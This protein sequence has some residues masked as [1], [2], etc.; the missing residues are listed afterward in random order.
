MYNPKDNSRKWR[1]NFVQSC[2]LEQSS[3]C[4]GANEINNPSVKTKRRP[5][6]RKLDNLLMIDIPPTF[7]EVE[8]S[9]EASE[10][11]KLRSM[12]CPEEDPVLTEMWRSGVCDADVGSGI[13]SVSTIS[14]LTSGK[15][16]GSGFRRSDTQKRR[17]RTQKREEESEAL[18]DSRSSKKSG[19][20]DVLKIQ[21]ADQSSV[22]SR[23]N[24][25]LNRMRENDTVNVQTANKLIDID[26]YVYT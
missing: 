4:V 9:Q 19:V 7:R 23:Y 12:Y 6:N 3:F 5:R 15:S 1:L 11:R 10:M 13:K 17:R 21:Q 16:L 14:P 26:S 18:F 22:T 8:T 20:G 2:E 24:L 25:I